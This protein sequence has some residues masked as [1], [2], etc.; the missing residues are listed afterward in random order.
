MPDAGNL[1]LS[2]TSYLRNPKHHF[3][4]F[5]PY[6]F[7][8][9]QEQ[10]VQRKQF[11]VSVMALGGPIAN[12]QFFD[13]Y[14]PQDQGERQRWFNKFLSS[15]NG[16]PVMFF[17]PDTGIERDSSKGKDRVKF[18]CWDELRYAYGLNHTLLI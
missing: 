12:C 16:I 3:R 9:L 17:D 7:D 2:K 1:D 13:D 6:V 18:I 14:V 10:V 8:Y 11:N 4:S 15:A 5:D